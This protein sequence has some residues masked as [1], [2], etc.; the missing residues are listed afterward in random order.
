MM[1]LNPILRKYTEGNWFTR[2]QEKINQL[3]YMDYIKLFA[4]KEKELENF[5]Q[6]IRIYSQYIEMEFGI[7]KCPMLI[8]RSEKRHK[9]RTKLLNQ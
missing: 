9:K 8:M 5:I 2:L 4:K 3:R 6:T 1:P 7:E